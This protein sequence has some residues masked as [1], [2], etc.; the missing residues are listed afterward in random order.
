MQ[1][2]V[3][4]G[5]KS[6]PKPLRSTSQPTPDSLDGLTGIDKYKVEMANQ[7]YDAAFRITECAV[8]LGICVAIENPTNGHYWNV[9]STTKIRTHF[10]G[11]FVTFHACAQRWH[12]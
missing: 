7:L 9:E 1:E 3:R 11:N 10:G 4:P 12:S 5:Q 6:C 2:S 8:E